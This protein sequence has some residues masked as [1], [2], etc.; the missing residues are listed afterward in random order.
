MSRWRARSE[1]FTHTNAKTG[2]NDSP[3]LR[4]RKISFEENR[5]VFLFIFFF[6]THANTHAHTCTVRPY[7]YPY[8]HT[9]TQHC[10]PACCTGTPF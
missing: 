4:F 10:L 8:T 9:H 3:P 7:P 2:V 6:F 5:F 1:K